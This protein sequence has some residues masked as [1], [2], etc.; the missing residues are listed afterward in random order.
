MPKWQNQ[1]FNH[2]AHITPFNT[3]YSLLLFSLHI[4]KI[5]QAITWRC[6]LK[7]IIQ[8]HPFRALVTF[9]KRQ[10]NRPDTIGNSGCSF[11]KL[12]FCQTLCINDWTAARCWPTKS[13]NAA[14]MGNLE[15]PAK[16]KLVSLLYISIGKTGRKMLM[17]KFPN[18]NLLLIELQALVQNCTECFQTRRNRTLDCHIFLSRKQKPTETLHQLWNVL[19]GLAA[20]YDFGNQTEGLV[21]DIF[22]LN[23]INK[24]VQEKLCTQPKENPAEALQFAIAF[25][26]G[27]NRQKSYGYRKE[28]CRFQRKTSKSI[29]ICVLRATRE[30]QLHKESQNSYCEKRN[31]VNQ[32]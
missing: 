16:R 22:V 17:G 3:V 26:D 2:T 15:V 11:L 5:H 10:T 8:L 13:K 28:I 23:M 25:E 7:T 1:K 30:R 21:H 24:Q 14:M 29:G 6:E 20:C 27:L 4:A 31:E 18:I 19:N 32:L 12:L 9:G